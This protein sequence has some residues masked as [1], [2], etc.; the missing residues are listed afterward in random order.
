MLPNFV[1]SS[2]DS[3]SRFDSP[4]VMSRCY[5][6]DECNCKHKLS[7]NEKSSC[8]G[9]TYSGFLGIYC[10]YGILL[11]NKECHSLDKC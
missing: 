2:K 1:E 4:D 3:G 11:L 7:K 5:S 10:A 9:V 6:L 8:Y